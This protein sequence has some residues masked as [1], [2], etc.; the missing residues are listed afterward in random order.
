MIEK[1][2]ALYWQCHLSILFMFLHN[3]FFSR[4]DFLRADN[5]FER[6]H[7]NDLQFLGPHSTVSCFISWIHALN[8]DLVHLFVFT[9]AM[10]SPFGVSPVLT[11][12]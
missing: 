8:E 11:V 9:L 6:I 2:K 7:R 12:S 3:E 1:I 4:N 5:T 10:A